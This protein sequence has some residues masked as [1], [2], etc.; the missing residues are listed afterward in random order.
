MTV[1]EVRNTHAS[2][3]LQYWTHFA[4]SATASEPS[5]IL[6]S[7]SISAGKVHFSF[8]INCS[9]SLFWVWP[10]SKS[11]RTLGWNDARYLLQADAR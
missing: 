10:S 9:T 11:G 4:T 3:S 7:S 2:A 6:Y 1:P 5:G 8:F